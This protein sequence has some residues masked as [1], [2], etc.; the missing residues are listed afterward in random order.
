VRLE[1]V[2]LLLAGCTGDDRGPRLDSVTPASAAHGA[3]VQLAGTR[4]CGPTSNCA[5]AGGEVQ[6]GL[7][8]PF[9]LAPIVEYSDVAATVR[10]PDL[11]EVGHTHLIVTVDEHSSNAL[12]FEV[13]AP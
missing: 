4:L 11:A 13:L 8:P 12:A 7:D 2:V 10:V 3:M 9:T 6:L 1:A 5:S